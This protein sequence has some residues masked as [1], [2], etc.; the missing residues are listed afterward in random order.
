MELN[1]DQFPFLPENRFWIPAS[2]YYYDYSSGYDE[3]RLISWE[4]GIEYSENF[5]D[6]ES[7]ECSLLPVIILPSVDLVYDKTTSTD[8]EIH[9]NISLTN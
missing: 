9:W 8:T 1:G 2:V 3:N 4:N 5:F 6:G 7:D